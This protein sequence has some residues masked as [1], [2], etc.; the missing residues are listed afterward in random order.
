M[1]VL[2]TGRHMDMTEALQDYV[3]TKVERVTRYLDNIK[4]ADVILSVE[5]YRHSAEVTIKANGI[6]I[7]GEEETDDMYGSIDRVMDK[8]ERQ[9]KKYKEKIR[10]H[11]PRQNLKEMNVIMNV[12][13]SD[14][15]KEEEPINLRIVKT[16]KLVTRAMSLDEAVMQMDLSG[17][18][19][20]IFTNI[21]TD[22]LCVIYRRKDDK[23]VLVEPE[24]Q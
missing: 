6:T 1:Q 14:E 23:L 15:N 10:Q 22:I 21:A 24:I 11:K 12:L 2:I 13:S 7:N 5:K 19:C 17:E 16:K 18:D 9:V 8:I 3:K 4:E 20:F